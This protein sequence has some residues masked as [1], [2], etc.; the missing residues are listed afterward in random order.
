MHA[1]PGIRTQRL[2]LAAVPLPFEDL[3]AHAIELRERGDDAGFALLLQQHPEHRARLDTALVR[4]QQA[5]LIVWSEPVAGGPF[6]VQVGYQVRAQRLRSYGTGGTITNRGGGCGIR[7]TQAFSHNPAIGSNDFECSI[8]GLPAGALLTIFNLS[9]IVPKLVCGPCQWV[10]FAITV[11]PP[12]VANSASV[13]FPIPCLPSLVGETFETQ[14]TT[15][16]FAQAPCGLLPGF[17]VSDRSA[18]SIGQ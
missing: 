13:S 18:F 14:W 2:G 15:L 3:L 17:V 7:G 12:I 5:G 10:P 6:G 4:L 16:D 1:A 8:S 11:T 9:A